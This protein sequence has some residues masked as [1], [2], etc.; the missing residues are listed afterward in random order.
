MCTN[1]QRV[2]S[3]P[4]TPTISSVPLTR[5]ARP[6]R[7]SRRQVLMNLGIGTAGIAVLAACGSDSASPSGTTTASAPGTDAPAATNAPAATDAVEEVA[8]RA[9]ASDELRLEHV[10]LGFVSAYVLVRGSE[11]AIVDTGVS[12]SGDAIFEAVTG[13]G[14]TPADIRHIVLTHNHSDHAGGLA[15]LEAEATNATVSAGP[16]DIESINTGLPLN[17]VTDGD[18]LFGL[19]VV[20]TPGHTP[21]SISV[22]DTDTGLIVAGDAINGDNEGGLTGA[23]PDFTPDMGTAAESVAKLAALMP[24]IAAFGHGGPPVADDVAAKLAA[25]G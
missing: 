13:L 12:G 2:A 4:I 1:H 14:L 18:E 15:D 9:A 22:F 25:L 5:I 21:G 11:V 20:H 23:N 16:G 3:E 17:E 24:S 7:W 10:S 19:G 8:P 6:A